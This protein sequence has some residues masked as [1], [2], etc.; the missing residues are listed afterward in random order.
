M[1]VQRRASLMAFHGL[2]ASR[3]VGLLERD[4]GSVVA[5]ASGNPAVSVAHAGRLVRYLSDYRALVRGRGGRLA[6][7]SSTAPLRVAGEGGERPVDLALK[8]GSAGFAPVAPVAGVSIA[9]ASAAG[10][11]VGGSGLRVTLEGADVS[12]RVVGSQSVFF[13]S[14]GRDVDASVSPTIHGAEFFAVLR[15]RLSPEQVRYRVSLPA[16]A[17]VQGAA[18]GGAAVVRGGVVLAEIKPPSA[19]DAQGSPVPVSMQLAGDELVLTVAHRRLSVAYPVLV[20]PTVT[21]PFG[22]LTPKTEFNAIYKSFIAWTHGAFF[23]SAPSTG[24]PIEVAPG[25]FVGGGIEGELS[26]PVSQ[27]MWLETA[28]LLGVSAV[29]LESPP[30]GHGTLWDLAVCNKTTGPEA[31]APPSSVVF[32]WETPSSEPCYGLPRIGISVV[33]SGV[34]VGE[35]KASDGGSLSVESVVFKIQPNPQEEEEV[36]SESY[37]IANPA[38]PHSKPCLLGEPVNCATGNQVESQTD[39]SVGGR[40]PGLGVTRTYNSR[41]ASIQ[42]RT[43]SM[44]PGPFGY[45]WTGP[46]NAHLVR[47]DRCVGSLSIGNVSGSRWCGWPSVTVYEDNGSS[48]NFLVTEGKYEAV[49]PLVKATLT[50]EGGNYVYTLPNQRKLTFNES[51][52]LTART[53]RNG[54]TTSVAW[55]P[56]GLVESISDAAGRKLT[57]AYNAEKEVASITDPMGHVVKYGYESQNLTSVTEPGEASPRWRFKYNTEHELTEMIDGRGNTVTTEYEEHRVVKQKDALGRERKWK[58]AEAEGGGTETKSTEPNGAVTVEKFDPWLQPK[59]VT[60]AS[61]TGLAATT[62]MEYDTNENLVKVTDP[63]KHVTKYGYNTTG[64]R[65]SELNAA[66]NEAKWTYNTTH[67]VLTSTTPDGETTTIKRDSHGN[68]E[69]IE[70]PAP[71]ATTQATKYKYASNGDLES[72]EDP[73]KRVTKY[74]YDSYGDRTAETDPEGDKRTWGYNE[75]SQETSTVSPRGNVEGVEASK[76]TTKLELDAQGRL[77]KLTDPLGHTTKYAYDANS[78]V[79]SKT[80]ANANKTKYTY[81]AD[82]ELTLTEMPKGNTTET[83]YDSEGQVTSQTDGDK[84]VTKYVRNLLEQVTEIVDAKERKTTK[85]YDT[86]GNLKA[87][88]DA[89]GRT[90]SYT[91]DAAS[92]PKEITYSDGKTP[93]VKYEYNGD[94]K[95]THMT[96]GTGESTYKYDELDR[97]TEA[98]NGHGEKASYEYDL[99]NEQTKLTYPNGKAITREYDKAGRLSKVTD[100]LGGATKFAYD[101]DSDQTATTFPS[102]TSDEDK[103][104]FDEADQLSETKM[105]KG[106]ET[107]ASLI[108][109]RDNDGQLKGATSK[110]LPGEEKP[111][112]EYDTDNRLTKGAATSYQYGGGNNPIKIGTGS[113][114][115]D[116]ADEIE[117]GPSLKYEYNA[118]GQ[119]TKTTPTP[120]PATTYGYDQAGNLISV[121]RPAE[122]E[123]SAIKD[124]YAYN[125]NGIRAS[126]TSSGV[127]TYLAWD[128]STPLPLVV[129]SGLNSFIYGPNELPIEQINTTGGTVFYLHHDQQGSTRLATG[130]TGKTEASY[131]YDAYGNQTGHT[132]TITAPLGY[133]AQYTSSD[134]GLIYLRARVYDPKTVQFLSVDPAEAVTRSPYFYTN[135]NPLNFGDPTGMSVIGTLEGVAEGA[136]KAGVD[137]VAVGPYAVYYGSHELA[138]GINALG[139]QFG[140]PGEVI[141]HLDSLSLAQLQALGLAGDAAIDALKNQLFGHES[142]CDEGT[143]SIVHLNPLHSYVPI[144]GEPVIR[145]APGIGPHGEVEIE[146]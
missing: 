50:K 146:W 104:T 124:T 115:Y 41:R 137:V 78:N 48:A 103:Y 81:D 106:A 12:G 4:F 23:V 121:E 131:T 79:E 61:G 109:T 62:T 129:A 108:Y 9:K 38:T 64:D 17:S 118:M 92:R 52:Q 16:G 33:L 90:T 32:H 83:G 2:S 43:P 49:S 68:P 130:T 6:V 82:N 119:R 34:E 15:S 91:Y 46:A 97:L 19:R 132:G 44:P 13:A 22:G 37:G 31:G 47:I 80:D 117:A 93:A 128:M 8:A 71:G 99:A 69:T 27:T 100:W 75:D 94:G 73:L 7:E 74:E 21:V 60:H 54:N 95:M 11:A 111:A 77:L 35:T 55:S 51:G 102:G 142:I 63:N 1:R 25:T 36:E 138:R 126:Q 29:K 144:P 88:T 39:L 123:T 143:G 145:N 107:L 113:Y 134:T 87:I 139:K 136:L 96:D 89:L 135:D 30:T 70:R 66:G 122:G 24:F 133:D 76:Y 120:G 57:F 114:T 28:E 42:N 140:L 5:G 53:D 105:S 101:R 40:G 59:S 127:T 65:T 86:A 56:E 72:V 98:Q 3:S 10:V 58:Y 20:D 141:A 26:I 112:Y 85:E 84:H 14:V 125:G 18:G 45:G 67:D 116:K 110:G